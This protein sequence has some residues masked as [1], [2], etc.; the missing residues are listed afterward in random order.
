LVGRINTILSTR[1]Q[2]IGS[3]GDNGLGEHPNPKHYGDNGLGEHLN[4]SNDTE[5]L[6]DILDNMGFSSAPEVAPTEFVELDLQ[7]QRPP[8]PI[9]S[10]RRVLPSL[11]RPPR[12]SNLYEPARLFIMVLVIVVSIYVQ[13]LYVGAWDYHR[14]SKYHMTDFTESD[15]IVRFATNQY[16]LDFPQAVSIDALIVG[17]NISSTS[18]HVNTLCVYISIPTTIT[19]VGFLGTV[20]NDALLQNPAY[21]QHLSKLEV[22]HDRNYDTTGMNFD[23]LNASVS[24]VKFATCANIVNDGFDALDADCGN[25]DISLHDIFITHDLCEQTITSW[26][27]L[28][29]SAT[30]FL[31]YVRRDAYNLNSIFQSKQ[32]HDMVILKTPL[33][34][35]SSD[36]TSRSALLG[37]KENMKPMHSHQIDPQMSRLLFIEHFS[38]SGKEYRGIHD[39][40]C[41]AGLVPNGYIPLRYSES[42]ISHWTQVCGSCQWYLG[43]RSSM[44]TKI[45]S[46]LNEINRGDLV[47][48]L[49][50]LQ[51]GDIHSIE[52]ACHKPLTATAVA[53]Y[54][55]NTT[56]K[57]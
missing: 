47:S 45:C 33:E 52:S 14:H 20:K 18:L 36:V 1:N 13:M 25:I 46:R 32:T 38:R 15:S 49:V 12:T 2:S 21:K 8:N 54:T 6:K 5:S 51:M 41:S 28:E 10:G 55:L 3:Y 23:K 57:N 53:R 39:R 35:F 44:F 19:L 7:S 22:W 11:L 34:R 27:E 48:S 50:T 43:Y 40:A 31:S 29:I 26:Q 37:I 56:S 30:A 16:M 17:G 4:G 42:V 9:S 24:F